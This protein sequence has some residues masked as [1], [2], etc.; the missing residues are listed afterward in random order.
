MKRVYIVIIILLLLSLTAAGWL[1]SRRYETQKPGTETVTTEEY[2]GIEPGQAAVFFRDDPL[3]V[4]GLTTGDEDAYLPLDWVIQ[5]LNDHFYIDRNKELLIYTQPEDILYCLLETKGS[6]GQPLFIKKDGSYYIHINLVS[7]YT[8]A[9]I[10]RFG[11]MIY[12]DDRYEPYETALVISGTQL[13]L[14]PDIKSGLFTECKAGEPVTVIEDEW[15]DADNIP[16]DA[17]I[18]VR[19]GDGKLGWI[20]RSCLGGF[21]ANE[22]RSTFVRPEYTHIDSAQPIVMGWHNVTVQGA[23]RYIEDLLK[24]R[25]QVNVV[26]PTWLSLSGSEG[27]ISSLADRQYVDLLHE[28]GISVWILIDN[29]DDSS[30]TGKLLADTDARKALI[31]NLM[32]TVSETGADGINID[33][34][35]VPSG[36]GAD[37]VQFMREL[38]V[39]CR[40]AHI[41]LSADVP[42]PAPFN[43]YYGRDKLAECI[44]YV[45]SME[46]DE[47]YSGGEAGAISSYP[48]FLQGI[49]DTLEQ[50]PKERFIAGIPT[51]TRI[52]KQTESGWGSAA[53]SIDKAGSWM[54]ENGIELHRNEELRLYYGEKV[55]DGVLNCIWTEDAETTQDKMNLIKESGLAGVAVWKLENSAVSAWEKIKFD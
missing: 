25:E 53:V 13:R 7:T 22:H 21:T 9:E 39:S 28:R 49:E 48:F 24:N 23:N 16:K 27:Q 20:L 12:I 31:T 15:K 55:I 18:K 46:Y 6:R 40:K 51:Y 52:W 8:D 35:R 1:L 3:D 2:Y 19:T 10:L 38:S 11:S 45:I 44:D 17:F 43:K 54:E 37:Y 36:S 34:E 32:N 14:A 33:F 5:E 29:F 26:S 4:R 30:D 47:H 50:V 42:A 41:V